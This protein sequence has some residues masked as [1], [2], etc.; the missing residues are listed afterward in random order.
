MLRLKRTL[1]PWNIHVVYFHS[2]ILQVFK[3]EK[4]SCST[5]S[6]YCKGDIIGSI[7]TVSIYCRGW[8][9]SFHF[10]DFNDLDHIQHW[11]TLIFC[12]LCRNWLQQSHPLAIGFPLLAVIFCFYQQVHGRPFQSSY[13]IL[14]YRS[15][16]VNLNMVNSKFHLIQ[17]FFSFHHFM[18]KMHR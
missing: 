13:L 8:Y 6:I 4:G 11:P 18:L 7:S 17:S 15:G 2:S 14:Y 3:F 9:S 5:L 12:F 16:T 10:A 1:R